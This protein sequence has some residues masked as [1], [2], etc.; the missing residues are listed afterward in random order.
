MVL[1]STSCVTLV[2]AHSSHP[3]FPGSQLFSLHEETNSHNQRVLAGS[4]YGAH[5]PSLLYNQRQSGS[6]GINECVRGW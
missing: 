2:L 4:N 6:P 3:P 5:K 1:V